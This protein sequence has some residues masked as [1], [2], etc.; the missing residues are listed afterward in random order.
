MEALQVHCGKLEEQNRKSLEIVRSE[1]ER[2]KR[3][4]LTLQH[5]VVELQTVRYLHNVCECHIYENNEYD[6]LLCP[7]MVFF[8]SARECRSCRV[9]AS[10]S[11]GSRSLCWL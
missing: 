10:L 6:V 4:A 3:N 1:M 2:E 8:S 7:H 5:R 11:R 9:K